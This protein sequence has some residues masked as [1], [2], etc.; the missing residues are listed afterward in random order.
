MIVALN[1]GA[2]ELVVNEKVIFALLELSETKLVTESVVRCES[3]S[4]HG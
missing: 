4:L 3:L 1:E 2:E